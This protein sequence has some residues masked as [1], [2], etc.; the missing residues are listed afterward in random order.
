MFF[1]PLIRQ[2]TV[3]LPVTYF[4]RSDGQVVRAWR[5]IEPTRI[6]LESGQTND[7]SQLPCLTLSINGTVWRTSRQV[8]LCHGEKHL[9]GFPHLGVVDRWPFT[10][11]RARHSARSF[12]R[13]RRINMQLN[14]RYLRR[15]KMLRLR[16]FDT[17]DARYILL[18]HMDLTRRL[19]YSAQSKV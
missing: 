1:H 2:K 11:K 10:P 6:L 17:M 19:P 16:W 7:F 12:S 4:I 15:G 13:D 5:C 9:A 18:D 14:T 8:Y 3:L